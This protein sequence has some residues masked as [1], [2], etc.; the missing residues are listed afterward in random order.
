MFHGQEEVSRGITDFY[1]NLYNNNTNITT[2][3]DD[4]YKYCPKLTPS[5]ARV[6]DAELTNADLVNALKACKDS[7]PGP[8]GIPYIIYKKFWQITGPIILESWKFSVVKD[9]LPPSHYES[10]ITLLPKEGKDNGD[11][12]NWRPITLSNC[13]SKILTKALSNKISKVLDSILDTSQTAYIPGRSV[14]DNLRANFFMKNHCRKK[15]IDSVLISLDAKKAFDSVDHKYIVDTLKAYG[16]G[17]GFVKIFKM[18]Y[19]DITARILINGF[20]SESIKIKRGV[21]QGDALSCAIFI[22][23]I[24]PLLRNINESKEIGEVKINRSNTYFKA[25]AYA[26]DVSVICLN[27]QNHIQGVFYEYGRLTERSGLEL[28]AEKTEILRLNDSQESELTITYLGNNVTLRTV[29]KIKIC[30]LYFCNDN[31]EEY[32]LNV[33]DKIEKLSYKIKLWT[34][35]HLTTEG[36]ILIIKTFGL[37]QLIYNM[38][39]YEFKQ[40]EIRNTER[41]IFKFIWSTDEKQNGIDQISRSIMK[42]E[43]EEGGMKV[44]DVECLDRSLK[45]RQFIRADKSKH[46]IAKIQSTLI[47]S[48]DTVRQEY[49]N[50]TDE[51]CISSSAQATLNLLIDHNRA[52]YANLSSDEYEIDKNLID[53]VSSINIKTFLTRKNRIFIL[54]I[55]KPLTDLGL[56]TLGEL[57]QAHEHETNRNVNKS[58][59]LVINSFPKHLIDIA[60]C[61]SEDT[62]NINN[63]L[64]FMRLTPEKITSIDLITTK[65]IQNLLKVV[66]GKVEKANFNSRL[67]IEDFDPSNITTVRS[68]CKNAKLRNIYFRLIHNDFFT[69]SRMFRYKMTESDECPR[70]AQVETTKHLLWECVHARQMWQL[71]NEYITRLGKKETI[72]K[73]YKQ[74]YNA[75]KEIGF[76]ILKLR[77]IQE[78]IQIKRPTNWVTEKFEELV[79]NIVRIEKYNYKR[80]YQLQH[81]TEKWKFAENST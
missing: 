13:D 65:E 29:K 34:P 53:E 35:R 10:V 15:K 81:F 54:C 39:T 47:G 22:I 70:C 75:C 7:S 66:L 40:T 44:T 77:L 4:F 11:I 27:K 61:Y 42:N 18:L 8:D 19:R 67:G 5:Q 51:E 20:Q 79:R 68:H 14:A 64:K 45:L 43:Y 2:K 60:K 21:K 17:D 1:K 58:M 74:I 56:V 50:I 57:M 32:K 48:S 59:S 12:K 69:H 73:E 55:L 71:Y 78:M 24:D 30:G 37:S 28:N 33:S 23:C 80:K 16:F 52:Q 76:T 49:H 26:D 31:D 62:N 38:Q 63:N 41:I 36:K 9:T 3:N 6:V 72:I 46:V 25:G